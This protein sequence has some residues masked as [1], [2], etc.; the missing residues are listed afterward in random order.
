MP[1]VLTLIIP[2]YNEADGLDRL[3]ERLLG[4]LR[5]LALEFEILCVDDGSRDATL[6]GLLAWRHRE[7]AIKVI[8]FS[9]NFGKEAALSAGLDYAF[10]QAVIPMDADLQDPPELIPDLIQKWREENVDVV[11][12]TRRERRGDTWW[13]KFTALGFYRVMNTICDTPIPPN[14]GDFRLMDQRVV[15]VLRQLPERNR[16]MKGLFAWVGFRQATLYYDREPRAVGAAKWRFWQLWNLALDGIVAFSTAPLRLAGWAGLM[17]SLG[18]LG[19]AGYLVVLKF[20]QGIELP[21]YASIMVTLLFLGGIQLITLG[22]LGEYVGRIYVETKGRPLY[23]V[24]QLYGVTPN[25]QE[26]PPEPPR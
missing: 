18:A 9:R 16:F 12:A 2:M 24:R 22:I 6:A 7:P 19:Y 14:T 15:A 13:K 4:V 1:P 5:P 8:H 23:L 25:S 11:L 21:G 3:F 20:N 10:G 26:W 17:L